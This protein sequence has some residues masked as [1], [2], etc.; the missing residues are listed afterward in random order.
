[1]VLWKNL[2]VLERFVEWMPLVILHFSL[3]GNF[4]ISD[5]LNIINSPSPK[6]GN[7]EEE[8]FA[9]GNRSYMRDC[10]RNPGALSS[11]L[12]PHG[13]HDPAV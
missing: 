13:K 10:L 4:T 3:N 9:A 12:R 8:H 1:M 7:G 2:T 6:L 11:Q 5:T